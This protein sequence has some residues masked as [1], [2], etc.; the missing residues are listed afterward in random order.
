MSV[1][2]SPFGLTRLEDVEETDGLPGKVVDDTLTGNVTKTFLRS[3]V[4]IETLQTV[5][6][7]N[8]NH[9]SLVPRL[10]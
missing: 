1:R 3:R 2:T 6:Y 8:R 5:F 4:D 9:T 7:T 10:I